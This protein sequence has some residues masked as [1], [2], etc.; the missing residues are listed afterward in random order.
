MYVCIYSI[1]GRLRT[2]I[3]KLSAHGDPLG[4]CGQCSPSA[5]ITCDLRISAIEQIPAPGSSQFVSEDREEGD[6]LV[7]GDAG[8]AYEPEAGGEMEEQ[9][10]VAYDS[11]WQLPFDS[12]WYLATF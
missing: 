3:I 7:D 1:E 9:E 12:C 8:Q 5:A 2:K 10:N 11:C 6:R 4:A